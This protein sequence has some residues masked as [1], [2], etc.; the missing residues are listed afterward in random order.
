MS[1]FHK[2]GN[3]YWTLCVICRFCCRFIQVNLM[4]VGERYETTDLNFKFTVEVELR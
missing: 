1:Q 2:I 4:N 3:W